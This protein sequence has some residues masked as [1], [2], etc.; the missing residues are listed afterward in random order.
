MEDV[1]RINVAM[2]RPQQQGAGFSPRNLYAMDVDRRENRSCYT[3]RRFGH[4]ARNY[5]NRGIGMNR[6]IEVDQ[7]ANS[8]LNREGGLGSPN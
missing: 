3:C 7:D 8:N 6:R 5:R 2:A 4:L 1:E